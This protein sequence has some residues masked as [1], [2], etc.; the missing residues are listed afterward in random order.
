MKE[1]IL[2]NGGERYEDM[3]DHRIYVHNFSSCKKIRFNL[4]E[5]MS[6]NPVQAGLLLLLLLLLFYAFA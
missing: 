5:V 6:L 3:M 2:V 1:H 4:P